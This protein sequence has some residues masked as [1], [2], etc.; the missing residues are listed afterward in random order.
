MVVY[1][2]FNKAI[3]ILLVLEFFAL[4]EDN[5]LFF[6]SFPSISLILLP[7]LHVHSDLSP[8]VLLLNGPISL[9]SINS[10]MHQKAS[11]PL[12]SSSNLDLVVLQACCPAAPWISYTFPVLHIFIWFCCL[13]SLQHNLGRL[14]RK[15][16]LELK[17]L[18]SCL[19]EN[20]LPLPSHLLNHLSGN[21]ILG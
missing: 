2:L 1:I 8:P 18:T 12:S 21:R 13:I 10:I 5:C 9:I 4:I 15:G 19:F 16:A 17:F 6:F 7:Y 11:L 14:L 3:M 20:F